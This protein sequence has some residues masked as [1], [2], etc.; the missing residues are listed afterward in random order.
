VAPLVWA[1]AGC[2]PCAGFP[3]VLLLKHTSLWVLVTPGV[4]VWT[5]PQ[6]RMA[7]LVNWYR[8]YGSCD[9][10]N[11][12]ARNQRHFCLYHKLLH[13]CRYT[14]IFIHKSYKIQISYKVRWQFWW[15]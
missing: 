15:F 3:Q 12:A 4:L 14:E 9:V 1:V 8:L 6:P 2:S 10:V 7:F 11:T 5:F 13:D